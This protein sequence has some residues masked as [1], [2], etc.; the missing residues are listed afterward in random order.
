M[1]ED[2]FNL[3]WENI[4]DRKYDHG[5]QLMRV[6]DSEGKSP[7]EIAARFN[8]YHICEKLLT[9]AKDS[10]TEYD[11]P[12]IKGKVAHEAS[13]AGNLNILQLT[14]CIYTDK[15]TVVFSDD[16]TDILRKRDED[17]YTCLHLAAQ[18]GKCL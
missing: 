7:I 6:M 16:M 8:V 3:I 2:L 10:P 14:V 1:N 5:N 13:D 12:F 18:Q 17:D 9:H 15:K 11:L 4:L